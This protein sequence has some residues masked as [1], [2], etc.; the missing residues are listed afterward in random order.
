MLRLCLIATALLALPAVAAAS[1]K[2]VPEG[3][4]C[5]AEAGGAEL[6]STALASAEPGVSG[7]CVYYVYDEEDSGRNVTLTLRV[8]TADYDPDRSFRNP[9]VERGGMAVTEEATR[10]VSFGGRSAPAT[11]I[12]L[13]GKE[14]DLGDITDVYN[15]LHVFRLEGGRVVALEVE[16][17]NLSADLHQAPRDALLAAQN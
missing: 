9:K 16:Y 5:P 1:D 6:I 8:G 4:N 11:V 10:T 17:T 15:T 2:T 3:L 13:T 7:L 12:S 14:A